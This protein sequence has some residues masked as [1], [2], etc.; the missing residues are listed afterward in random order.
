LNVLHNDVQFQICN[1]LAK[2][3]FHVGEKAPFF[4]FR[5]AA[6]LSSQRCSGDFNRVRKKNGL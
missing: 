4:I 3:L 6:T 5:Q 2:A 1:E